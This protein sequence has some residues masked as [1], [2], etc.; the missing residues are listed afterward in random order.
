MRQRLRRW[1]SG[2]SGPRGSD[3]MIEAPGVEV[4]A[5]APALAGAVEDRGPET[6]TPSALVHHAWD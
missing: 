3:Q 5:V 2:S 6:L 4:E 1:A